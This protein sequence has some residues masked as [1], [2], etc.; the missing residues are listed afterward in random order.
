MLAICGFRNASSS[1]PPTRTSRT[2]PRPSHFS[3]S[4][5]RAPRSYTTSACAKTGRITPTA[6]QWRVAE[7][8]RKIDVT[9]DVK[10]SV[11]AGGV[12]PKDVD[13]VIVSHIHY[14]NY[15]AFAD[16]LL[17]NI[18][19]R[20]LAEMKSWPKFSKRK[21]PPGPKLDAAHY[22][23]PSYDRLH[24]KRP[25]PED[26]Q[27]VVISQNLHP[28]DSGAGLTEGEPWISDR[29]NPGR[30]TCTSGE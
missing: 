18:P 27:P 3:S 20:Y 28:S 9:K 26:P 25:P 7:G 5:R 6:I 24:R 8:V 11:V 4:I 2:K 13:V 21:S 1:S 17:E 12:D 15:I 29:G 14:D 16:Q 22:P 19:G 23:N 30:T 10:D